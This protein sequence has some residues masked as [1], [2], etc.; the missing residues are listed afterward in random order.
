MVDPVFIALICIP[1]ILIKTIPKSAAAHSCMYAKESH[2]LSQHTLVDN[3]HSHTLLEKRV[4]C[5]ANL[6]A[7]TH[8]NVTMNLRDQEMVEEEFHH[9]MVS[10]QVSVLIVHYLLIRLVQYACNIMFVTFRT[11]GW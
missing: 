5:L 11:C 10:Q 3:G 1:L 6:F 9:Y 8:G 2:I 7:D 4:N